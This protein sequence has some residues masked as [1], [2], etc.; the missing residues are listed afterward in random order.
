MAAPF[1][2]DV[3]TITPK[4]AWPVIR[5]GKKETRPKARFKID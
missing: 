4:G 5:G 3:L 1:T 2:Y